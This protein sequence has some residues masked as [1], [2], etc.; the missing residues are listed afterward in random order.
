M[1]QIFQSKI[2]RLFSSKGG[3]VQLRFNCLHRYVWTTYTSH[4]FKKLS[5]CYTVSSAHEF[6][7]FLSSNLIWSYLFELKSRGFHKT[8]FSEKSKPRQPRGWSACS[9][10]PLIL[11]HRPCCPWAP[12]PHLH[13]PPTLP[14]YLLRD[15]VLMIC[16][17]SCLCHITQQLQLLTAKLLFLGHLFSF[18][19]NF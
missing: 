5:I 1:K 16:L 19:I 12:Q 17:V 8:G 6:S 15:F 18:R 14:S 9:P 10:A 11:S 13:W 3:T 4:E 7:Y 2:L